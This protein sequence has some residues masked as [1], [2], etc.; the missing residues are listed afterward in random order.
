MDIE[1][2]ILVALKLVKNEKFFYFFFKKTVTFVL[3]YPFSPQFKMLVLATDSHQFVL[4][5]Y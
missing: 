3:K 1:N 2:L 4:G 5:Q